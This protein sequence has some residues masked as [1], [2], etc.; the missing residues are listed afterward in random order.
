MK[1]AV[2]KLFGIDIESKTATCGLC[3]SDTPIY[4]V[5][6]GWRCTLRHR[7]D[8]KRY[9]KRHPEQHREAVKKWR[10]ANSEEHKTYQ[11]AWQREYYRRK[12]DQE[13][14]PRESG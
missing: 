14:P 10:R 9:W 1:Y 13:Q 7:E 3:G 2:H 6:N 5:K 12:K 8:S 4:R 11:R